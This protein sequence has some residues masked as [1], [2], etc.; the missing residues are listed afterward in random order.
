MWFLLFKVI[1][2]LLIKKY[3][4]ALY[5]SAV[6]HLVVGVGFARTQFGTGSGWQC[7]FNKLRVILPFGKDTAKAD[8][9]PLSPMYFLI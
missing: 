3:C 4:K 9:D 2:F 8:I 6:S 5:G 1:R 7:L